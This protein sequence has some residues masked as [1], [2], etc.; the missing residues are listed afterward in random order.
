VD[1]AVHSAKDMPA[2]LPEGLE[3]A[4]TLPREDPRDALVLAAGS[5]AGEIDDVLAHL[6]VRPRIGTSSVRRTA[7]LSP[8]LP[9]AIFGA[10]R[11]NVD[12]R[13][14]KLDAGEYEALVLASAG[15]RRLGFGARISVA[16]PIDRCIPAPGQGIV[17]V[18]I[19][20]DD[21]PVREA[22][23][24]FHDEPAGLALSAER[25]L[26]TALGGGCQLPLGGLAVL[27]NGDLQMHAIVTS[28]DGARAVRCHVRG[29]ASDPAAVGRRAAGELADQGAGEILERV[30]R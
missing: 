24:P 6:G 19:R 27:E 5:P 13:L 16:I 21:A 12:S 30:R 1:L 3:I 15:L 17:A 20:S 8:L 23:R 29:P 14:R 26:V 7:Q 28:P 10:I 25:A 4:A 22:L 9:D 2:D 18:E 11:G